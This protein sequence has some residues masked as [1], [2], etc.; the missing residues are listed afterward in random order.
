MPVGL[1]S[2]SYDTDKWDDLLRTYESVFAPLVDRPVALLELGVLRG[3][4]LYLWRDHFPH[5]TI[6]GIDLNPVML[7]D[8]TGGFD[9]SEAPRT[10]RPCWIGSEK[11]LRRPDSTS[12]SM[13]LLI[14][15]P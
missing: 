4:S 3:G 12:S 13:T 2:G 15:E 7:D 14:L 9:S 6:V 5:G 10:M 11:K 1:P 8:P